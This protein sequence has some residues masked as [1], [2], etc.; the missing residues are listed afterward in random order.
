MRT[1]KIWGLGIFVFAGIVSIAIVF[2]LLLVDGISPKSLKSL[3]TIDPEVVV[4][5]KIVPE[6][7]VT[8][9][10]GEETEKIKDVFIV[11]VET[12]DGQVKLFSGEKL[13][14]PDHQVPHH[15][16]DGE[17]GYIKESNYSVQN[18]MLQ[19]ATGSSNAYAAIPCCTGLHQTAGGDSVTPLCRKR[20]SV[21]P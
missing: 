2:K 1:M 17:G 8:I 12:N 4:N 20:S 9:T 18:L 16:Q 15:S 10:I 21:C 6:K 13:F 19:A 14:R 11:L 7:E 3:E 5:E